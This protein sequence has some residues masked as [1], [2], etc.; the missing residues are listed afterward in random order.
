[1]ALDLQ[2]S[3]HAAA[4]ASVLKSIENPVAGRARPNALPT[5]S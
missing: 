3:A 5:S 4:A 2:S 1:M